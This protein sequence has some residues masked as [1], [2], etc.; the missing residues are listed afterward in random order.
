M[1]GNAVGGVAGSGNALCGMAASGNS[2]A[3]PGRVNIYLS[4]ADTGSEDTN[5]RS[6]KPL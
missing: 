4:A 2:G 6:R 3:V 5:S 1:R